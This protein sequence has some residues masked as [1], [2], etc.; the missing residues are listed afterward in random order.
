MKRKLR[1]PPWIGSRNLFTKE[2]Q[3]L[4][5]RFL[6]PKKKFSKK[7][8]LLKNEKKNLTKNFST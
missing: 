1:L 6:E 4:F 3:H 7:I 5:L 2:F 8:F